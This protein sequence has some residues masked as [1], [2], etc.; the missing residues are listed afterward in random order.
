VLIRLINTSDATCIKQ[1]RMSRAVF[2]KLCNRLRQKELLIDTFF[3]SLWRNK[4]QCSY[5][6]WVN[7]TQIHPLDSAELRTVADSCIFSIGTILEDFGSIS[8]H[9]YNVCISSKRLGIHSLQV[10]P[11]S[12]SLL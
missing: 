10:W 4:L 5:T 6:W 12:L 2:Y 9:I 8:V 3:M 7:I 11:M 1:L